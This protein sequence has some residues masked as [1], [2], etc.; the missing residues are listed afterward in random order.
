MDIHKS[1]NKK[2]DNIWDFIKHLMTHKKKEKRERKQR[3]RKKFKQSRFGT[4]I[5]ICGFVR[6]TNRNTV[7]LFINS[8]LKKQR[9]YD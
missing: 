4:I 9:R 1:H 3:R 6:T 7:M 8:Y 5:L 2:N